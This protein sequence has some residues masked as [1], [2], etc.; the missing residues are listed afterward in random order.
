MCV[1]ISISEFIMER[2]AM[3]EDFF[4]FSIVLIEL[5]RHFV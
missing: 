1:N 4:F 2:K 5:K 3:K